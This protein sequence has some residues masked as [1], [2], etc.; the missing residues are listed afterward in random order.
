MNFGLFERDGFILDQC[1]F[2]AII[3]RAS[4]N[5]SR[6]ILNITIFY[7]GKEACSLE[8]TGERFEY[9][10]P[11]GHLFA[12]LCNN[13]KCPRFNRIKCHLRGS[14]LLSYY[15]INIK[16]FRV[17]TNRDGVLSERAYYSDVHFKTY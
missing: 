11:L 8:K 15:A 5:L 17:R 10:L 7:C 13:R 4:S 1:A 14:V 9:A 3:F 16:F 6:G 12:F 2:W